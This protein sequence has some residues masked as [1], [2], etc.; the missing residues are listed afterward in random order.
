M[1]KIQNRLFVCLLFLDAFLFIHGWWGTIRSWPGSALPLGHNVPLRETTAWGGNP[2][3][4]QAHLNM[5]VMAWH[6]QAQH[7]RSTL[8]SHKSIMIRLTNLLLSTWQRFPYVRFSALVNVV[9]LYFRNLIISF[10]AMIP[11]LLFYCL[12]VTFNN[13]QESKGFFFG[14]WL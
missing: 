6:T 1:L 13:L 7:L 5:R 8:R 10:P 14:Q 2:C 3:M 9:N 12:F 11:L 4:T